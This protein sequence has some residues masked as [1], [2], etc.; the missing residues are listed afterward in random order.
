MR[1]GGLMRGGSA[2]LLLLV[3][4]C[5]TAGVAPVEPIGATLA[6][7]A[8][9]PPVFPAEPDLLDVLARVEATPLLAARAADVE[10]AEALVDQAGRPPNPVVGAYGEKIDVEELDRG[11]QK[12][13]VRVSERFETAGKRDA[14][15]GVAEGRAGESAAALK[16]ARIRLAMAA[17]A[18]H[19]RALAGHRLLAA[20][21]AELRTVES[22]LALEE[23]RLAA[24]RGVEAPVVALRAR[25]GRLRAAAAEEDAA[26]RG[27]LR[28]LAGL[29]ALPPG[30]I[31][32]VRGRLLDL[33]DL[34]EIAADTVRENPDVLES[35]ARLVT[36]RAGERD[37]RAKAWP[38]V[39]AGMGLE[40]GRE[41]EEHRTM[42]GLFVEAPLPVLDTN[43]GAIR[44]ALAETQRITGEIASAEATAAA[45]FA[46]R[47]ETAEALAR[48]RHVV[49]VDVVPA[50]EREL[51]LARAARRAGRT[52][53]GEVVE[54]EL[55]LVVARRE[56][57]AL[58]RAI[59]LEIAAALALAGRTALPAP[60]PQN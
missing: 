1:G 13:G 4:A 22:L 15:V 30:E 39:T 47:R 36:A 24:G 58:D 51:A 31:H 35:T 2:V 6:P 40:N 28:T 11:I 52:G 44:A 32:G 49:E 45:E 3:A 57:I 8:L 56:L 43:E 42:L 14:R 26:V 20:R 19:Q 27:A 18:A 7:A 41:G 21:E 54:A 46:A 10:R 38:D 53:D 25:A 34:P 29:L 23:K 48:S 50:V 59:A 60:S 5:A 37:A 33:E 12:R 9:A 55:A 17:T 16:A